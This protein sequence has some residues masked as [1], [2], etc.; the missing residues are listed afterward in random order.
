MPAS[1]FDRLAPAIGRALCVDTTIDITTI[2]RRS[3]RPRR[4]EIWFLHVDGHIYITGTTGRRDWLA[5]LR[6]EP[7]FTF[8][9]KESLAADLDAV[10]VEVSDPSERRAVLTSPAAEWYRGQERLDDL[11]TCAPMVRVV[12][13]ADADATPVGRT[14]ST[15]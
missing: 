10:A 4:I 6:A 14:G 11:V 13:E 7:R 3:G 12:F 15:R 2:G 1:P 5:N 8:H 9:L